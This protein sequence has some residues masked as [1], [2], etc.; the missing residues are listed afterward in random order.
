M[1]TS[2]IQHPPNE[3][4]IVI[5]QWQLVF[6]EGDAATAALLSYFEYWHN[7]KLE[8]QANA[9][10]NEMPFEPSLLQFHSEKELIE[11]I[12]KIATSR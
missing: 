7:V 8:I 4:L 11:G 6:C 5:H 1:K 9:K 10:A 12:L 3:P 2:C